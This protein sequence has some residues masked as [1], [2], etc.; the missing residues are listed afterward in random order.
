[1]VIADLDL[2]I[3][4]GFGQIRLFGKVDFFFKYKT[5]TKIDFSENSTKGLRKERRHKQR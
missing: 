5:P 3:S 1:M 4:A 2:V